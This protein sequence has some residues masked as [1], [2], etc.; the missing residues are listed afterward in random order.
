METNDIPEIR[1]KLENDIT[2][3]L[4]K[5]QVDTGLSPSGV[6]I[7]KSMRLEDPPGWHQVIGVKLEID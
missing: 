5:F 6:L 4:R 7:Y 2:D 3:L 1:R